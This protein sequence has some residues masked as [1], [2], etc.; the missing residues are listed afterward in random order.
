MSTTKS[1]NY[2]EWGGACAQSEWGGV[3]AYPM[4]SNGSNASWVVTV[5][6]KAIKAE[7][8]RKESPLQESKEREVDTKKWVFPLP[9]TPTPQILGCLITVF[10]TV[11]QDQTA[12]KYTH[13]WAP[14]PTT[15][16]TRSLLLFFPMIL[17]KQPL[18]PVL[19]PGKPKPRQEELLFLL[20]RW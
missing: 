8:F 14:P 16:H 10:L 9:S 2:I 1:S 15:S 3:C 18:S 5:S 12:L 19:L 6:G 13:M 7:S 17:N 4:G 20:Y 11:L